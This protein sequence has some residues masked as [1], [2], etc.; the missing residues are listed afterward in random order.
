MLLIN[1]KDLFDSFR[2]V[3]RRMRRSWQKRETP[4]RTKIWEGG[5]QEPESTSAIGE[6]DFAEEPTQ[7]SSLWTSA[8]PSI[9]LP[10]EFALP[11]L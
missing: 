3:M 11:N 9:I 7:L 6:C 8:L 4:K 2:M 5:Q 10:A 1:I